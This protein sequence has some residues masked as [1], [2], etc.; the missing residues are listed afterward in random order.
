MQVSATFL[1]FTYT[2]PFDKNL[3]YILIHYDCISCNIDCHREIIK[4]FAIKGKNENIWI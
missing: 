2:V 3:L 1:L 4:L